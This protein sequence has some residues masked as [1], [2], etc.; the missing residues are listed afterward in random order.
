MPEEILIQINMKDVNY[1]NRI[2]EGYEYLGVVT[3]VKDT[4][5]V[6]R[7]RVTPDTYPE[8]LEILDNLPLQ[9]EYVKMK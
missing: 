6:L 9:F 1:I 5:G 8:V 3:T 4:Q 2:M 7:I